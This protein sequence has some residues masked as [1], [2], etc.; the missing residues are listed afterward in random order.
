MFVCK[1]DW[2]DTGHGRRPLRR[3]PKFRSLSRRTGTSSTRS[4]LRS[5][6]PC[7]NTGR[8][9][10]SGS[11]RNSPIAPPFRDTRYS[12][13]DRSVFRSFVLPWHDGVGLVT[14]WPSV[15]MA[16][17]GSVVGYLAIPE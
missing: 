17:I 1:W 9:L 11:L 3:D 15:G 2:W 13:Q 12:F 7:R 5:T 14:L 4:D 16:T 6:R 8:A 10:A